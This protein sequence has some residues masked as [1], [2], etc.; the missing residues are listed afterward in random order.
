MRFIA[1]ILKKQRRAERRVGGDI[2]LLTHPA[3]L[4][5]IRAM[6]FL[7]QSRAAANLEP[8]HLPHYAIELAECHSF[9]T[10]SARR[11]IRPERCRDHALQS[12]VVPKAGTRARRWNMMASRP[13]GM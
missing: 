9:F 7:K 5:L 2:G 3:E 8:H 6:R 11:F 1:G 10:N 13:E 12:R 4:E